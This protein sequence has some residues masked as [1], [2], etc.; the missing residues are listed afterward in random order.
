[1]VERPESEDPGFFERLLGETEE[2]DEEEKPDK[3]KR[4][5]E[6]KAEPPPETQKP[7]ENDPEEPLDPEL[8]AELEYLA[9]LATEARRPAKRVE[10]AQ[11]LE[12]LP[13]AVRGRV[14]RFQNHAKLELALERKRFLFSTLTADAEEP[15]PQGPVKI[16]HRW[17][18]HR[19]EMPVHQPK[20]LQQEIIRRLEPDTD[21][22][23][24]MEALAELAPEIAEYDEVEVTRETEQGPEKYLI[25][26]EGVIAIERPKKE[27]PEVVLSEPPPAVS[28][29]E[30]AEEIPEEDTEEEPE[31]EPAAEDEAWVKEQVE[32][33]VAEEEPENALEVETPFEKETDE[34]GIEQI[35]EDLAAAAPELSDLP[36]IGG[37]AP[38]ERRE[39]KR[40]QPKPM[41][42]AEPIE[43]HEP[44]QIKPSKRSIEAR[45]SRTV[46]WAPVERRPDAKMK[47][48]ARK[49]LRVLARRYGLKLTPD[50]EAYLLEILLRPRV[51]GD[52][53]VYGLSANLDILTQVMQEI[54]LHYG[55]VYARRPK[56]R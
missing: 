46:E 50:L 27:G 16:R 36:K 24:T 32:Q 17:S 1:M 34:P 40:A 3:P 25:T 2:E 22:R 14:E 38:V 55:D 23:R 44:P 4:K 15:M 7:D 9:E 49:L 10:L 37:G 30:V 5:K 39:P 48:K 42:R 56:P 19:E 12:R 35:I 52:R 53:K 26:H 11:L 45:F 47:R 20:P 28:P 21:N 31:I 18:L 29:E 41:P 54:W 33:I 51:I 43:N 6:E 8:E 13:Q